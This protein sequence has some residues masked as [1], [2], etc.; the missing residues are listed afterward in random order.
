MPTSTLKNAFR[1][2][3]LS[4]AA[5]LAAQS[6]AALPEMRV[7]T[8]NRAA[9]TSTQVNRQ[10]GAGNCQAANLF[11]HKYTAMSFSLTD[12][13]NPDNNFSVSSFKD[14][15]RG[16][17]NSTSATNI[18]K[19]PYRL[20]F[21]EHKSMFGSKKHRSWALLA[22]WYDPSFALNAVAFELGRRLGLPGTPKYYFV[23][24]YINDSYKGIYQMTD[25]VQ[26]NKGRVDVDE[27]EGWL[28]EF[29]YHCPSNS[30]EI[31]FNTDYPNNP[32]DAKLHTY[33]KSPEDLPNAS[34]YQFV[35]NQVNQLTRAMFANQ[36]T[37]GKSFPENGYRDLIDLESMAKY[38]MIQM[39]MDNFDFNNKAMASG[40]SI[41][42]GSTV[43]APAS[44]FMHKDKNGRIFAGP[45]W[46]LD[47]AAGVDNQRNF[48]KHYQY[49]DYSIKPKH[50]F[51]LKFFDDPVF[52]A[53]WKKAWDNN[54]NIFRAMT[55]VMDSIATIVEGSVERNFALQN[56]GGNGTPCTNPY[57][58][59]GGGGGMTP[60]APATKQA[61][62]DE[63][64]KLKTW[65]NNRINYYSQE[66]GRLNIDVSKDIT[67]SPTSTVER[68][69]LTRN[70]LSV[71]K[72]GL[73]IKASSNVS[74]KVFS[75]T[76]NVIRKQTLA[77]GNHTVSLNDLP[78]GIYL[79][80]VNA[81]G[82]KQ[83]VKVAVR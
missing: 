34:D 83:T 10:M 23:D 41:V 22:N 16:R 60:D 17:G 70:G 21:D 52:L 54:V 78:R 79:A 48:P 77:A 71:V 3:A 55:G 61:Y 65:W 15:I 50:P 47:L 9:I 24:L 35:K 62:K 1:L 19:K 30:D 66:L 72:N 64:G 32:Q 38:V 45:L 6:F 57:M 56:G 67:Q 49:Y 74:I 75:L 33:I 76:G 25:L 36:Q 44:N 68:P 43:A 20:K 59:G 80:K 46:D 31:D 42:Q 4:I 13:A 26:V 27:R 82:V 18:S 58:C 81:N 63:I 53:K 14:S 28:V 7:T 2:S 8:Q 40:T 11:S 73:R 69:L 5:F 12:P 37:N 29:D 51:Y 39:F